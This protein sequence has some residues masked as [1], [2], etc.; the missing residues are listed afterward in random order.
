MIIIG[1][2]DQDL[3]EVKNNN[4]NNNNK[5]AVRVKLNCFLEFN[6]KIIFQCA[7]SDKN[8]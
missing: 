7:V 4:K 6:S 5:R 2:D 1:Q 8:N 3:T